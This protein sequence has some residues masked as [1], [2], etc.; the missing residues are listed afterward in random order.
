M[1]Y[2]ALVEASIKKYGLRFKSR[3]DLSV[4]EQQFCQSPHKGEFDLRITKAFEANFLQ[5]K[6]SAERRIKELI[7]E[8]RDGRIKIEQQELFS[9][10]KRLVEAERKLSEKVTKTTVKEKE[11]C[12][13]QISRAKG[14]IDRLQ[15]TKLDEN[16]DRIYP[17]DF[18]P[19]IIGDEKGERILRLSRYLIRPDGQDASFDSKYSKCYNARFDN[20]EGFP[21]KFEFGRNHGIVVIKR[22]FENVNRHDYERRSL[23]GDEKPENMI[24]SFQPRGFDYLIVP[25]LY[26]VSRDKKG[27]EILHSFALITD[28][29]PKEVA[30]AGHN[31]CPIFLK[32]EAIDSWLFPKGKSKE[33]LY[34]ILQQ[35]ERPFYEHH[36]VAA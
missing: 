26:D 36:V 15:S 32:E 11:V 13:R 18:A 16:S 2:S 3:I 1:C 35:R 4:L 14:R 33:E 8:S 5:P 25:C 7:D 6:D 9:F 20:L 29:P 28:D 19:L 34:S 22:F 31:R 27:N 21:W 23:M 12:E 30:E 17:K 10:K 24:V